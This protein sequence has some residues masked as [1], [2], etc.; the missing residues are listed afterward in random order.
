[1]TPNF[2]PGPYRIEK[3]AGWWC[4]VAPSSTTA[5]TAFFR[6]ADAELYAAAP[7]MHELIST[8]RFSEC[9]A[10][11]CRYDDGGPRIIHVEGCPAFDILG[12]IEG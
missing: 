5:L 10:R 3:A 2:T 4:V 12:Q 7:A 6:R 11:G 1:M 9:E 8:H